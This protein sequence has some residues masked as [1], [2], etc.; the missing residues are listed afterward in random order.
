MFFSHVEEKNLQIYWFWFVKLFSSSCPSCTTQKLTSSFSFSFAFKCKL[1]RVE[2][3]LLKKNK[4][5][6]GDNLIYLKCIL[7]SCSFLPPSISLLYIDFTVIQIAQ[8]LPFLSK[9]IIFILYENFSFVINKFSR[10]LVLI[11]F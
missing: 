3:F 4:K 10:E 6:M 7:L 5:R 9:K 8:L 11:K 2:V 1:M